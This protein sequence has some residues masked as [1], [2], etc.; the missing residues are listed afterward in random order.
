M[1]APPSF[2]C[3][4]CGLTS[5]LPHDIREGYCGHC[6][7]WTGDPAYCANKPSA[8]GQAAKATAVTSK[9]EPRYR[10]RRDKWIALLQERFPPTGAM[11]LPEIADMLGADLPTLTLCWTT[12]GPPHIDVAGR[13][14]YRAEDIVDFLTEINPDGF[15]P[16]EPMRIYRQNQPPG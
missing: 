3:P 16:A 12:D 4:R 9:P 7:D 11:T 15:S 5:Y 8:T 1:T 2:T 10:I 6:H 13:C 14:R